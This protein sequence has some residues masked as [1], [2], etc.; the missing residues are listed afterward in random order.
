MS[1]VLCTV[2][3]DIFFLSGCRYSIPILTGAKPAHI[4]GA[5]ATFALHAKDPTHK[6]DVQRADCKLVINI[7]LLSGT[8]PARNNK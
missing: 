8:L 7:T 2:F 4:R 5:L 6:P 3:H 1:E